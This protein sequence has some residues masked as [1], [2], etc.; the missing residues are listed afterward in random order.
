MTADNASGNE[1]LRGLEQFAATHRQAAFA[2]MQVAVLPLDMELATRR[3]LNERARYV[4]LH[5]LA[6][7]PGE[8]DAA[9]QMGVSQVDTAA[10]GWLAVDAR[11][12]VSAL[13]IQG[14]RLNDWSTAEAQNLLL[15]MSRTAGSVWP[16]RA[17]DAA[18][19]AASG[20]RDQITAAVHRAVAGSADNSVWSVLLTPVARLLS[21]NEAVA[22]VKGC[23]HVEELLTSTSTAMAELATEA[24]EGL[25]AI[26]DE[27]ASSRQVVRELLAGSQ[28]E[29]ASATADADLG[30]W[31]RVLRWVRGLSEAEQS[32]ADATREHDI[33]R[34]RLAS[35]EN[36]ARDLVER[37][38]RAEAVAVAAE[39]YRDAL[40]T[41]S[42][43]VREYGNS[44][45]AVLDT[46][47]AVA[48]QALAEKH[49]IASDETALGTSLNR[50]PAVLDALRQWA[51]DLNYAI[52]VKNWFAQMKL[53]T[54]IDLATRR[55]QW[56]HEQLIASL[57]GPIDAVRKTAAQDVLANLPAD[58][59]AAIVDNMLSSVRTG[60]A[61]EQGLDLPPKV[62]LV[63][64]VPGGIDGALGSIIQ[65]KGMTPTGTTLRPSPYHD[66]L[67]AIAE[68]HGMNILQVASV[69]KGYESYM[70]LPERD[71]SHYDRQQAWSDKRARQLFERALTS[72]GQALQIVV[73]GLAFG[74]ILDTK[75]Q[76]WRK[77]GKALIKLV[78]DAKV[79]T[80]FEARGRA[81]ASMTTLGDSVPSLLE[82]LMATPAYTDEIWAYVRGCVEAEGQGI[83]RQRLSEL[84]HS[85]CFRQDI[86]LVKTL[87]AMLGESA[88][89]S[90]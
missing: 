9:E 10:A 28:R 45:G 35:A 12:H 21:A 70:A 82:S 8:A 11:M 17:L 37:L 90:T 58:A 27:M 47:K 34:E 57:D 64:G 26:R 53:Q 15:G 30:I 55:P 51:G 68:V 88:H 19:R 24:Q 54:P 52:A 14:A 32:A 67:V 73:L 25:A 79:T 7:L 80:A 4:L 36:T 63:L 22:A 85:R 72:R 42:S 71:E 65:S 87:N 48:Q 20:I 16:V 86:D 41:A 50:H 56:A 62:S 29:F 60:I 31:A 3:L 1:D 69:A 39:A 75:A 38:F 78:P 33:R 13:A 23:R 66:S 84:D 83:I 44:I 6:R 43:S 40:V 81:L 74:K 46:T 49:A 89:A 2:Q 18:G 61:I 77:S 59:L 76:P 5:L